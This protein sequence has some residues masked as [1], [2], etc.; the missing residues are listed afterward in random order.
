MDILD[1]RYAAYA[2]TR[3]PAIHRS[4][5]A[6]ELY[7]DP[8]L[9]QDVIEEY[10]GSYDDDSDLSSTYDSD[11][12]SGSSYVDTSSSRLWRSAWWGWGTSGRVVQDRVIDGDENWR[13]LRMLRAVVRRRMKSPNDSID[14]DDTTASVSVSGGDLT[15]QRTQSF[16]FAEYIDHVLKEGTEL[17]ESQ[18]LTSKKGWKKVAFACVEI[19]D[20]GKAT[21]ELLTREDI[22]YRAAESEAKVPKRL[23]TIESAAGAKIASDHLRTRIRRRTNS[24]LSALTARDVRQVDPAFAAKPALWVR[25]NAIIVSLDGT[26]AI[27]FRNKILLFDPDKE[28]MEQIIDLVLTKVAEDRRSNGS[29]FAPFE[30]RVLEAI[31][32]YVQTLLEKFYYSEI[33]HTIDVEL[34]SSPITPS[35]EFLENIRGRERNLDYFTTRSKMVTHA[36]KEVLENDEDMAEMYLTEK[37]KHPNQIRNSLDHD[38]VE[39]MLEHYLQGIEYMWDRADTI[40]NAVG[41]TKGLM[42]IELTLTQNRIL[43]ASL[44]VTITSTGLTG[45]AMLANIMGMNLPFAGASGRP[46]ENGNLF[47]IIVGIIIIWVGLVIF[48]LITWCRREGLYGSKL[49]VSWGFHRKR[50]ALPPWPGNPFGG[51]EITGLAAVARDTYLMPRTNPETEATPE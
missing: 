12:T 15:G 33:E 44:F 10:V 2:A 5:S 31:L 30:F 43:L 17:D 13:S 18:S 20:R 22:L 42:S 11:K 28:N 49:F 35:S 27:I 9:R 21:R 25:S 50:D 51:D 14:E 26:R 7:A 41:D 39:M 4:N 32:I 40:N 24:R 23:S 36:L 6:P 46:D 3:L 29:Y 37:C 47:Y 16:T 8:T 48:A 34:D 1:E 45:G 19:D 38:E